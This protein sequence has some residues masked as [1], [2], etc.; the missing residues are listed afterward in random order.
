MI[1]PDAR[2]RLTAQDIALILEWVDGVR[3]TPE[4]V[5]I[6]LQ[7]ADLDAVLDRPELADR[8]SESPMPGPSPSLYFYILV[9][10]ALVRHG[11][12]DRRLADYCAALL[13][14]FGRGD[15]AHR[16]APVDDH[17]H[18]YLVDVLGDA[19]SSSGERQ[20]RV[21]VH[22]GNYALWF[23]G[24]FPERIEARRTRRGGPDLRYYDALGGKG[25]A[26]AS[27]HWLASRVGL[28]DVF[29]GAA[30]Q[31]VTLRSALNAVSGQ[32]HLRAA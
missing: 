3:P 28:E 17:R 16:I 4:D 14:E 25:Y 12:S 27:D 31:F 10:H 18:E 13:R 6:W 1:Q 7:N 21:L 29:R 8:L 19:A 24:V 5:D 32:L 9:R 15:R 11:I 26:E 22:L 30:E 2:S 23:A 20:F